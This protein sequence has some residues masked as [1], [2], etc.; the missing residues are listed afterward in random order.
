MHGSHLYVCRLPYPVSFCFL[1]MAPYLRL[2]LL[3]IG[4]AGTHEVL[5]THTPI[6]SIQRV[7]YWLAVYHHVEK[8]RVNTTTVFPGEIRVYGT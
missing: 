7:Q 2:M 4:I 5:Y 6:H 1:N 3:A 8:I